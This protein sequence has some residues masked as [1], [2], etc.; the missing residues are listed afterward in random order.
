MVDIP[1]SGIADFDRLR[2][3]CYPDTQTVLIC[4]N[5]D[6]PQ[7]ITN[8]VEK[9]NTEIRHF[10]GRCSVILV[11]CKIDLREDPEII[12]KLKQ[13]D[14]KPIKTKIG[15]KIAAKIHADAYIECSAKTHE[16][17]QELFITAARL[18]LKKHHY[19]K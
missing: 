10:C 6:D 7:S 14:E 16:G 9:W 3:L 4:F 19:T 18:V 15:K 8:V 5:V 13:R 12:S 11:A 2:P 1:T 17:V